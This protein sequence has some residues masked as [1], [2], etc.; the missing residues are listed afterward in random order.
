MVGAVVFGGAVKQGKAGF[1]T[2]SGKSSAG[3]KVLLNILDKGNHLSGKLETSRPALGNRFMKTFVYGQ[4]YP[5]G[6]VSRL[7][8]SSQNQ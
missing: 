7:S 1:P 3:Q 4:G 6:R 5:S 8:F 2:F